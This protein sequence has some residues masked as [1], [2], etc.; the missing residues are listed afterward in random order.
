MNFISEVGKFDKGKENH[1]MKREKYNK[2]IIAG[3]KIAVQ[4]S[5]GRGKA[6]NRKNNE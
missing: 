1:V 6:V 4:R 2:G 5:I 3:E